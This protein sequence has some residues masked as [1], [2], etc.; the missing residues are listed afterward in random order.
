MKDHDII[1][2]LRDYDVQETN[3]FYPQIFPYLLDSPLYF[4]VGR[5]HISRFTESFY[6]PALL[7]ARAV[8]FL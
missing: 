7:T 6:P 4:E 2:A 1:Q 3:Y 8:S 5:W